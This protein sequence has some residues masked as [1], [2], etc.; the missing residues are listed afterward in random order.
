MLYEDSEKSPETAE[1]YE[2][3]AYGST[4]FTGE[5]ARKILAAHEVRGRSKLTAD[6]AKDMAC[7]KWPEEVR[8]VRAARVVRYRWPVAHA[9]R[10]T[11]A[12]LAE[13]EQRA[14][15]VPLAQPGTRGAY[16]SA[17]DVAAV[18]AAGAEYRA[19]VHSVRVRVSADDADD[20]EAASAVLA[21]LRGGFECTEPSVYGRRSGGR[22]W[23]FEVA[24]PKR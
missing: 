21:L 7:E 1:E 4:P 8:E 15:V 17:E 22:A 13:I 18:Y 2:R 11:Y 10:V 16:A 20:E 3:I 23:Y 19:A 9:L 14:G 12:E 24:V 5:D 6:E